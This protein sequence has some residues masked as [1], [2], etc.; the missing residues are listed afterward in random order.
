MSL[1]VTNQVMG[2][3]TMSATAKA[4]KSRTRS[5]NRA[6]LPAHQIGSGNVF[7]DLELP[8]AGT[9][10]A[11]GKLALAIIARIDA[12]GLTQSQAAGRMGVHQPRASQIKCGR[13][14]DFSIGTLLELALKLG[15]DV[16]IHVHPEQKA[17]VAGQMSVRGDLVTV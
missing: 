11:K 16:D 9:E 13:L 2:G 12:L 6:K 1:N 4:K 17:D 7:A 3:F 14:G 5:S 8:D 10:L 15:I